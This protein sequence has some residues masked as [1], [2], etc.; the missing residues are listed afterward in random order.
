[1]MQRTTDLIAAV[2]GIGAFAVAVLAGFAVGNEPLGVVTRALMAMVICSLLGRLIGMAC[3]QAMREH[4]AAYTL[5]HPV[6]EIESEF[7]ERKENI[8]VSN[9]ENS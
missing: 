8:E 1:M 2:L 5:A 4:M 3:E 7:R 9:V 6:P